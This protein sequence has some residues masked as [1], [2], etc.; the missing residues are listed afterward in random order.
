[1]YPLTAR[2]LRST[3]A[4]QNLQ[5]KLAELQKK[6]AKDKN[7]LAQEQ[8][9]LY[10]ESGVSPAGCLVPMLVQLPVWIAVYQSIIL[11]LA[12]APEGLLS[13]SRYLYPWPILYS[14]LPLDSSFLGMDLSSS[15]N[16]IL[17][18]L[19]GASMWVQQKMT[20]PPV[21]DPKQQAQSQMMLWMMPMMFFFLSYTFPSGLALYW[22][23][24]TVIGI[25]QQYFISGWG[26]LLPSRAAGQSVRDKKYKSRI[27]QVEQASGGGTVEADISEPTITQEG[28]KVSA[29]AGDKRQDRG[30]GYP[31]STRQVRRQPRTGRHRHP[32]RR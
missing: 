15:G 5:P 11:A 4:M 6:Y 14:M 23:A 31:K 25:V 30:A 21:T 18:L 8:M 2:Q 17:A 13:L 22:V 29:G 12:T 1:M 9:K 28:G 32:K 24:S 16:I 26:S 20:T 27:A 7:K 3:K 19:V 10:K